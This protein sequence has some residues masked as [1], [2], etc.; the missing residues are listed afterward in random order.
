[1]TNHCTLQ[2]HKYP[3][4]GHLI[5]PPH[6]PHCQASY[7]KLIGMP[8]IWG[9]SNVL[10]LKAQQHAWMATLNFLRRCVH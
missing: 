10:H 1:M 8:I 4:T 3:D 2:I 9:G 5:E 6:S 7:H